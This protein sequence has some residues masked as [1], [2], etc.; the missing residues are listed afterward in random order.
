MKILITSQIWLKEHMFKIGAF[1]FIVLMAM[2]DFL[3]INNLFESLHI[4]SQFY[5]GELDL[6]RF[7]K[8]GVVYSLTM[9]ILLEGNPAFLGYAVSLWTDKTLAKSND[10]FNA[11]VGTIVSL[12]GLLITLALSV[13]LRAI[14]IKANGGAKA[15]FS[16]VYALND[17]QLDNSSFVIHCY[18]LVSPILTSLLAFVASWSAFRSERLDDLEK[19]VDSLH[20]KSLN[21]QRQFLD[22]KSQFD[23]ARLGLWST[24]TATDTSNM[25]SEITT[26]RKE[27]YNRTRKKLQDN[28]LNELPDQI[29]H[30]NKEIENLLS[31]FIT[32]MEQNH[33]DSLSVEN[34][35][36]MHDAKT[37]NNVD[38]WDS[39]LATP[40]LKEKLNK[41]LDNAIVIAQ[42]KTSVK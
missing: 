37:E 15:Y 6:S 31:T 12:I 19:K 1:I 42:F 23:D 39:E 36:R 5:I 2:A 4:S 18:L 27:F 40:E 9:S 13:Y 28:T 29:K 21:Y 7:I 16:G 14:M 10:E 35:I 33:S 30:Y 26:Y 22:V 38:K 32:Q 8:E 41:L 34:L 11:K 17:E 3:T 20:L 25:P 24:I